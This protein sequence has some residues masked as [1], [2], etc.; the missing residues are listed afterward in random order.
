MGFDSLSY[1]LSNQLDFISSI[2]TLT[3]FL[4]AILFL[5]SLWNGSGEAAT[6][7]QQSQ[8]PP[9]EA[10]EPDASLADIGL[11]DG[12][13]EVISDQSVEGSV[14]AP[15]TPAPNTAAPISSAPSPTPPVPVP[16]PATSAPTV[17]VLPTA[18]APD[19]EPPATTDDG[20]TY[21]DDTYTD[22]GTGYYDDT[23]PTD[24]ALTT[25]LLQVFTEPVTE[26]TGATTE[27]Y[28]AQSSTQTTTTQAPGGGGTTTPAPG[29]GGTTTPAPEAGGGETYPIIAGGVLTDHTAVNTAEGD[30]K[31]INAVSS[32][33]IIPEAG[34]RVIEPIDCAGT[35]GEDCCLIV[36][37]SIPDSDVNGN[38]IQCKIT[39]D[40]Y[41]DKKTYWKNLRGKKVHIKG[42]HNN[43]VMEN[44]EMS[45]TWPKGKEG[46]EFEE[47]LSKAGALPL[48]MQGGIPQ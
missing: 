12:S 45:G 29:G 38:A 22:D 27:E 39:Y 14:P 26:V 31:V 5:S 48:I 47:W 35:T 40:D 4:L 34:E 44:P 24:D 16:V 23:A 37:L 25:E 46:A 11:E 41:T 33:T 20:L 1:C 42:N 15:L 43:Y 32:E 8:L 13:V 17:G 18:P 3:C 2:L 28:I 21:T 10:M 19:P 36:K 7:E 6:A 30:E 9:I